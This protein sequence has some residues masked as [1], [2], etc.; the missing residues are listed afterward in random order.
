MTACRTANLEWMMQGENIDS[1]RPLIE[2]FAK[3]SNEDH[4]GTRLSDEAHFPSSKPPKTMTLHPHIHNLL[5]QLTNDAPTAHVSSLY[6]PN[7]LELQK[8]SIS[9]VIYSS[10]A[11]LPWD[12]NIIFRRPGGLSHRVGRI[13]SI[14][15]VSYQPETTFLVV[16]QHRFISSTDVRNVYQR[17]GFAGGFLC[18]ADEDSRLLV[19]RSKDVVCH[20]AKIVLNQEEEKLMHALPLNAVRN[21]SRR[22][23]PRLY[24]CRKC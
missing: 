10:E 16:S 19:I 21:I 3:V 6:P 1:V 4:R 8:V 24:V 11:T 14:F 22:C 20:F 15:Q 5:L 9:G 12:S 7:A 13:K 17:F 2:A 23:E 18:N